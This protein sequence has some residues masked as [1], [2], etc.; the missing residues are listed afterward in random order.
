MG[1]QF[2]LPAYLV[3][4]K[5]CGRFHGSMKF[6]DHLRSFARL[7]IDADTAAENL[8]TLAPG[9]PY[10]SDRTLAF[11]QAMRT[12]SWTASSGS[13]NRQALINS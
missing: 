12:T 7:R 3:L 9:A 2:S 13:E 5:A 8:D 11:V 1:L 10:D 4:D 6:D